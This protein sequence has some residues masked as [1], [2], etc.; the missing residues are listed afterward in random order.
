L[1]CYWSLLSVPSFPTRRSSD[2]AA[3]RALG[4]TIQLWEVRDADGFERVF[5]AR[6]KERPDGL[7]VLGG[8][9]MRAN[10]KRILGF[11][12]KSRLPSRSEDTRLNSSHD[13]ISYA[14]FCL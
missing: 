7:Y 5:A 9:L 13:Q 12:L 3:A 14:V 1:S 6:G 2:L 10:E 4:L 8:T 11:A